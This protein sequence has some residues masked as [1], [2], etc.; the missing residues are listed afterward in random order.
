MRRSRVPGSRSGAFL[1]SIAFPSTVDGSSIGSAM[2]FVKSS[3]CSQELI[4]DRSSFPSSVSRARNHHLRQSGHGHRRC[5]RGIHRFLSARSRIATD[6]L[7]NCGIEL[8][9]IYREC[10]RRRVGMAPY[11][12][13]C[14]PLVFLSARCTKRCITVECL[15]DQLVRSA[16]RC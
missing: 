2:T 10:S 9:L 13:L 12:L 11:V 16:R 4:G 15:E 8:P 7:F 14:P 1:A 5:C 3:T 6:W